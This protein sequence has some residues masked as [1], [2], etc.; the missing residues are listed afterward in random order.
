MPRICSICQHK[1]RAEIDRALLG[2]DSIG[3]IAQ[4]FG[5]SKP[6]LDRHKRTH[7]AEKLLKAREV[8][9]VTNG[10]DLLK[11]LQELNRETGAILALAKR[12]K[13]FELALKA[14]ARLERQIE[15]EGRLIGEIKDK[16]PSV[17]NIRVVYVDKVVT[18]GPPLAGARSAPAI[19]VSPSL[20]EAQ[21]LPVVSLPDKVRDDA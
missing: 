11:R 18:N 17:Q 4:R 1:Q 20:R 14:I 8:T 19:D 15:L 3:K 2:F 9:E 7:L 13:Q 5:T 21:P 6:A 10:S 16:T 12:Q